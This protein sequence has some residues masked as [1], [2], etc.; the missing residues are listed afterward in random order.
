MGDQ[1]IGPI[2]VTVKPMMTNFFWLRQPWQLKFFNCH[3]LGDEKK[4]VTTSLTNA[5]MS[6]QL[7]NG[8]ETLK[9][10]CESCVMLQ[11]NCVIRSTHD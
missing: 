2:L 5:W 7:Y 10:E 8:L 9:C 6:W 11:W 3:K 4:L 1:I